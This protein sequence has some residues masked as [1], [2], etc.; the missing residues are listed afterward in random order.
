MRATRSGGWHGTATPSDDSRDLY[1][2]LER[3]NLQREQGGHVSAYVQ[4]GHISAHVMGVFNIWALKYDFV[5]F[6]NSEIAVQTALEKL[7]KEHKA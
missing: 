3:I 6:T 2:S 7:T 4:G 5:P 1:A